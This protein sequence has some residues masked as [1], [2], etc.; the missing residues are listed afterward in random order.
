ME[1]TFFVKVQTELNFPVIV[2]QLTQD[3]IT[4][5]P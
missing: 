2:E 4:D 1:E 3:G 5:L